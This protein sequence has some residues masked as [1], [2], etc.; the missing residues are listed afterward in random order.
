M[1]HP[2][3]P[4]LEPKSYPF[5]HPNVVVDSG[6]DATLILQENF[7]AM[8]IPTA[9]SL[10]TKEMNSTNKHESF[11]VETPHVSCSLL[12]SLEFVLLKTTCPY[13][14]PNL[15]LILVIILFRRMVVYAFVDHKFCKSH[16]CIVVLTL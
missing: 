8:D 9:S 11:S 7:Y 2:P 15:I 6:R 14:D 1:K 5:V 12:E 4:S 3:S 13:E 10:E 16:S